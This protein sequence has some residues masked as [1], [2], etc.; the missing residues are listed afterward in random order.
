MCP[1][2]AQLIRRQE[3]R[4]R[5]VGRNRRR[6]RPA[7]SEI[8][9]R[10][11]RVALAKAAARA[12]RTRLLLLGTAG[13]STYWAGTDRRSAASAVAVGDA[14]YIVDCGD[15]AGKR[16]Q[17]ALEPADNLTMFGAL[18]AVFLTH[19]HSDHIV[20]LPNL[21]LY[22]WLSGLD[23]AASPLQVIGPGRRGEMEPVF[24]AA[25]AAAA[26][27]T[28]NPANPTPGTRDMVEYLY[29]AFATD[30]NDRIRDNGKPDLRELVAARD[31]ALPKIPGFLSPN[32]TPYPEMP[33]FPVYEDDRVRV[34]A[35]LVRHFPIWP[36]FA[37]RFETDDGAIVF[38]GDTAPSENL[39]ALATGADILVH[40]AIV[41]NWIDAALPEPRSAAEE[42]MRQHS[43]TSH[44]P[45][46]E[47]GKIGEAAGVE[48]LV[49]NHI[50]PG[51]ASAADLRPARRGFSGRLVIGEDL[52]QLGLRRARS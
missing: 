42:A 5:L 41:T 2:I 12:C 7:P 22:G 49:L 51:N 3:A 46:E 8:G 27:R 18:R 21:L 45:V 35:T 32:R 9:A 43:L 23:R 44:T 33:P 47:V 14:L 17:E 13:G 40:E 4:H 30:I 50:V 10:S 25:G 15:G 28:V 48:T 31:I 6:E 34:S 26:P 16:L 52:L 24:A 39:V 1:I 20:D 37:F 29:R 36:A 11:Q 19:L 38:S